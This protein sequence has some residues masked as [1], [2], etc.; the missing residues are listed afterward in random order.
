[1]VYKLPAQKGSEDKSAKGLKYK[2]MDQSSE[3]WQDGMGYINSSEGAVGRSLL[4]LYRQN[5]S[6][7][8]E[9]RRNPG[10][11]TMVGPTVKGR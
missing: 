8:T 4:P 7:V 6:Q 11:D 10:W 2:Y 9:C 5:N 3:G 1:M